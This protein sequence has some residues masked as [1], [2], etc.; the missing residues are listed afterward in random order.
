MAVWG[1][2]AY[3]LGESSPDK[4]QEFLDNEYV[5][6]GWSE[7]Q[8]PALHQMLRA[9]K[10][11]DIVF[12]KSFAVKTKKLRIKAVG[13]VIDNACV[14]SGGLGTG[15]KVKWSKKYNPIEPI[16][17]TPEIYRNNVFKNSIYEEYNEEIIKKLVDAIMD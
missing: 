17:I 10:V 13:I 12:I 1:F 8:A 15:I 2:G 11:G 14:V 5:C 7:E 3:Y 9:I 16:Y 4:S 6:V